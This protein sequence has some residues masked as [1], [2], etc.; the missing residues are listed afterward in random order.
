MTPRLLLRTT[1]LSA[2]LLAPA[3][4]AFAYLDTFI[5]GTVIGTMS[6]KESTAFAHNVRDVLNNGADGTMVSWTAPGRQAQADRRP[7][8]AAARQVRQ[9]PALPATEGTT[10]ARGSGRQLDRLVLQ[11]R[12]RPLAL[13][14]GRERLKGGLQWPGCRH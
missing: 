6:Q 9:G 3:A 14:H 12:R 8:D 7:A 4:P 1:L 5:H 10:Q 2:A 11:A 13:A